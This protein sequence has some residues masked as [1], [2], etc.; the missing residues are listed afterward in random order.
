MRKTGYITFG[1][2]LSA[3]AVVVM[4][5][6]YFPYLTYS[7]PALAGMFVM[8]AVIEL[9]NKWALFTYITSAFLSVL[10]AEPEAAF[11]Y[12]CLFGSYPI[13][14]AVIEKIPSSL[15]RYAAK[16]LVFNAAVALVYFVFMKLLGLSTGLEGVAVYAV[17]AFWIFANIVF[18]IYD[19]AILRV[20]QWYIWR[21]H[22]RISKLIKR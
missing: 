12:V 3:L 20:S 21:L 15:L 5:M 8:V 7:I 2:V 18:L 19:F 16:L 11:L 10:F 1:A 9:G 22:P 13:V 6:S 4:L 17:A 14:K